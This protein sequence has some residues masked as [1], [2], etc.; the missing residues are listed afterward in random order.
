MEQQNHNQ[1][2]RCFDERRFDEALTLLE[3]EI[4][5][6]PKPDWHSLYLAGQAARFLNRLQDAEKYLRSSIT[7]GGH[8]RAEVHL[9]LGI[10]LQLQDKF[11]EACVAFVDALA[12]EKDNDAVLNSLALTYRKM[13]RLEDALTTYEKALTGFCRRLAMSLDNS[14]S[15]PIIDYRNTTGQ[16]WS[17]KA[18]EMAMFIA[19]TTE[20]TSAIAF[21]TGQSAEIEART[22]A[23]KGL[24]WT[25]QQANGKKT[26][27][28]LP[29]F[30]DTFREQLRESRTY[31]VLLN[32]FGGVL[33]ALGRNDD[34]RKCYL[35]S[36]EF[37]PSSFDYPAPR[38]GLSQ[39]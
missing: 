32:N 11:G 20:G 12:T 16:L 26:V 28:I 22:K 37:T 1:V 25:V 30:F 34:A 5:H 19:V 36:I 18:V 14:P 33:A 8:Q 21:P 24:L 35:E 9:G 23:H 6:A 39:L 29:N 4:A 10:V 3:L 31:A 7:A 38:H 17:S 13:N 2:R 27:V 15:N